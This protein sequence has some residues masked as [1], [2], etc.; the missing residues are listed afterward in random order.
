MKLR[1]SRLTMVVAAVWLAALALTLAVPA[2][3]AEARMQN[4]GW[5]T[6]APHHPDACAPLPFDC[7][8]VQVW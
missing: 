8:V 6:F 4:M 1:G 2:S 5:Y 3:P 7:Y